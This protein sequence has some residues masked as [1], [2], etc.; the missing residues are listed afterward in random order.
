MNPREK[1]IIEL[2]AKF[3]KMDFA[4]Q[5]DFM[6]EVFKRMSDPNLFAMYVEVFGK[7]VDVREGQ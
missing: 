4:V 7:P 5:D 6:R 3:R 2:I 1:A